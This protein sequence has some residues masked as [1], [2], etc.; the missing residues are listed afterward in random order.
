MANARRCLGTNKDGSPCSAQPR[1]GR[2]FCPWHDP[3]LTDARAQWRARGGTNKSNRSRARKRALGG[4]TDF[5]AIDGSLCQALNDVLSGEIEPPVAS[6]MAT[7]ARA[8]I[9]V[10][11]ANDLA[12]RL[13]AVEAELERRGA[14]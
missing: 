11:Q 2:G 14:S 4:G 10:R 1:T 13:E 7:L 6:S 8:I 3:A 9:A 12:A 5:R